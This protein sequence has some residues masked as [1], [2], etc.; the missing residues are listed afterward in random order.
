MVFS[1]DL[2]YYFNICVYVWVCACDCLVWMLGVTLDPLKKWKVLLT[3]E[4]L[5][6]G[7]CV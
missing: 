6:L 7:H 4:L 1:L 5:E 3:A 2:F